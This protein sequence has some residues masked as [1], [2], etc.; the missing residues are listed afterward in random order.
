MAMVCSQHGV[1]SK[2]RVL[3]GTILGKKRTFA[4]KKHRHSQPRPWPD[5]GSGMQC[6]LGF[7]GNGSDRIFE[8]SHH[9]TD[10]FQV[11]KKQGRSLTQ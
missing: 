7:S 2:I 4:Q 11:P 6:G 8:A 3:S 1:L 10:S 9:P 5:M